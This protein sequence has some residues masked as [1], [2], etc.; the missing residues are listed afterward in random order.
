[1]AKQNWVTIST[2]QRFPLFNAPNGSLSFAFPRPPDSMGYLYQ[3]VAS[4]A[5][6]GSVR[7][8]FQIATSGEP[9]FD[10]DREGNSCPTPANVRPFLWANR[11]G[12]G[13]YDR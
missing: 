10:F 12:W 11:D 13:D 3:K 6:A 9:A 5:I 7:V 1:M 8:S 4:R 2:P